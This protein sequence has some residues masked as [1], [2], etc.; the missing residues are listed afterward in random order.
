M[1]NVR[2]LTEYYGRPIALELGPIYMGATG[3]ESEIHFL[4]DVAVE[5]DSQVILD[6]THWQ[7]ANRNLNRP[8]EYGLD[9]F[10]ADRVVELHVAGMRLG[11][12]DRHWHDAHY[13][14]PSDEVYD[15]TERLVNELPNLRAVTFEHQSDG[16]ED[17]FVQALERLGAIMEGVRPA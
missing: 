16:P 3:C 4:R 9:V 11:S 5:T 15:L 10:P 1:A 8:A 12:D 6:V 7:I 17:E 2:G 14:L 13:L